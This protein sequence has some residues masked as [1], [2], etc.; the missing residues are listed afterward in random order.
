[1]P[2]EEFD[3]SLGELQ[4]SVL[5]LGSMVNKAIE[6]SMEALK[7]RNVWTAK[8]VIEDDDILDEKRAEIERQALLLIATQQ[9]LARDL[10]LIAAVLSISSEL[11]RMGDYA[12]G[13]AKISIDLA[14]QPPLTDLV[15]IPKMAVKACD[16][17]NRSLD[18]FTAH[19]EEAALAI[20]NEDDVIDDLYDQV[21]YE[22]MAHMVADSKTIPR[23]TRLMWVGHNLER[24][25]DRVTNICE[26]VRFMV[27]GDP[28]ES[29][30]SERT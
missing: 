2:R 16:M 19:D 28:Y 7:T 10:R 24:I 25:A 30:T 9:P 4:D 8:Q 12:E 18:A 11:E 26:R 6:R 1:M 29:A 17:L 27:V 14:G 13:I 22:L 21:Y 5:A 3:H 20:W 15:V 23:A